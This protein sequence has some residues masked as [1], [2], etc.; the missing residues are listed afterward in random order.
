M[1]SRPRLL[2]VV[3]SAS[4]AAAGCSGN[5][6]LTD[7]ASPAD[8]RKFGGYTMGGGGR[9]EVTDS[10]QSVATTGASSEACDSGDLRGGFTMGGGGIAEQAGC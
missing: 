8:A 9:T 10:T 2:A 7:E 4:L 3:L 6:A 1:V 5:P